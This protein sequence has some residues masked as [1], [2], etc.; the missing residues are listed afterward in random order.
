MHRLRLFSVWLACLFAVSAQAAPPSWDIVYVRQARFGDSQN[1]TWPEVGHPAEIDPGA[2]LMLLHP[3][4]SEEVLV[5]AGN[6]AVTDPVVS[7]DAQWIYYSFFPDM[8]PAGINPQRDL[9]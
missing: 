1:T 9:P 4:G 3:D 5:D 2:D 8:S 6:G 7:F